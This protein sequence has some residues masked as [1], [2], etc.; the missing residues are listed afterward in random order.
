MRGMFPSKFLFLVFSYPWERQSSLSLGLLSPR[1]ISKHHKIHKIESII[2][3]ATNLFLLPSLWIF[4]FPGAWPTN[5]AICPRVFIYLYL[6]TLFF[7]HKVGAP[8]VHVS[9]LTHWED[10]PLPLPWKLP[11]SAAT[12]GRRPRAFLVPSSPAV[13]D[14]RS[15]ISILQWLPAGL[16]SPQGLAGLIE[17]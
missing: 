2:N 13:P 9:D 12:V 14:P 17:S 7:L 3:T 5:Q 6:G 15:V 1:N 16:T 10:F 8:L 11:S 4:L